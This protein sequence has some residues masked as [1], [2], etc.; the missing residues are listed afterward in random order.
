[1]NF[2]PHTFETLKIDAFSAQCPKVGALNEPLDFCYKKFSELFSSHFKA[3][4]FITY[5]EK[6]ELRESM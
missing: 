6:Y 1:M 3:K 2:Y 4:D 5:Y